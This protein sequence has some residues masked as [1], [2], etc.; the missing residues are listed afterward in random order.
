MS[1]NQYFAE[2]L[3]SSYMRIISRLY[4]GYISLFFTGVD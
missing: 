1:E 3:Y 2:I 4:R